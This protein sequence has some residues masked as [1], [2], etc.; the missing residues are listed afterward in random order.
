MKSQAAG[1]AHKDTGKR[2]RSSQPREAA[3]KKPR[4]APDFVESD[5]ASQD[6]E[7]GS[8]GDSGV[9]D[10][11]Q[12][13][14]E[15]E[16]PGDDED[17]DEEEVAKG[18]TDEEDAKDLWQRGFGN[19]VEHRKPEVEGETAGHAWRNLPDKT[20][21]ALRQIEPALLHILP[22]SLTR[23]HTCCSCYQSWS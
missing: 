2:P 5:M 15:D 12:Y 13:A 8:D 10:P 14:T 20:Q 22:A 16:A 6:D 4:A 21:R 17:E 7:S 11:G 3:A 1:H 19:P 23:I 9:P 18:N